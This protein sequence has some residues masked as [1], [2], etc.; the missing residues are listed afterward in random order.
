MKTVAPLSF[1]STSAGGKLSPFREPVMVGMVILGLGTSA[2]LP[3]AAEEFALSRLLEGPTQTGPKTTSRA[4]SPF[5]FPTRAGA[6]IGELRRITGLTWDQLARLFGVSRRSLHFWASGKVMTPANEEHLQ[7]LLAAVQEIDRGSGSTNRAQLLAVR[8]GT[9]PFDLLAARRY[10]D[11]VALL[12]S[13]HSLARLPRPRLSNEAM[14]QRATRPP[15]ELVGALQ[16]R[17]HREAG[18]ARVTKTVRARSGPRE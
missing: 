9:I 12:S 10:E 16:D 6:A 13:R 18:I 1:G 3:A 17:V 11:V 4:S 2:G 8:E 15:E 7:R 14:A 5:V